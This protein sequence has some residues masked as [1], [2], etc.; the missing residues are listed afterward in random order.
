MEIV[1]KEF[2]A[3]LGNLLEEFSVALHANG[4]L[5]DGFL[6]LKGFLDEII[7]AGF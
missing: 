6:P 1:F 4:I 2:L 5:E 7:G 3:L